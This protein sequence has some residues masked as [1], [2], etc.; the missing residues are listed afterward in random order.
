MW[1][2]YAREPEPDAPW[3]P[4]RRWLAAIDAVGWPLLWIEL[5]AHAPAPLGLVRPVVTGIAVLF[6]IV[7]LHRAVC[8]NH[9]YRFTTWWMGRIVAGLLLVGF[10]LKLM[11]PG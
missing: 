9:R 1:L 4:G 5:L 3:W 6:G 2:V 7:R 11:M 10:V 8:V